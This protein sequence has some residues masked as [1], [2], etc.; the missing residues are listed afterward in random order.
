MGNIEKNLIENVYRAVRQY[1]LL[2]E[3]RKKIEVIKQ[4]AL[5]L[6]KR[7][8]DAREKQAIPE[9]LYQEKK[10]EI[11][12]EL[13]QVS[14]GVGG[15]YIESAAETVAAF[16]RHSVFVQGKHV[17]EETEREEI[18]RGIENGKI[19]ETIIRRHIGEAEPSPNLEPE[20][21]PPEKVLDTIVGGFQAITASINSSIKHLEALIDKIESELDSYSRPSAKNTQT[22]QKP[23]SEPP[24]K[25]G[26]DKK[27]SDESTAPADRQEK[28]TAAS[29]ETETNPVE[30]ALRNS[31]GLFG[32]IAQNETGLEEEEI[33]EHH[34]HGVRP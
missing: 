13:R 25:E 4:K 33:E 34:P 20:N 28:Q 17:F 8:E 18:D 1:N 15:Q 26:G 6:Q 27:K 14:I 22:P 32:P 19:D 21:V 30:E 29:P 31:Y 3:N 10:K 2:S 7:L 16:I 12:N 11:E 5:H 23:S 9:S 24:K